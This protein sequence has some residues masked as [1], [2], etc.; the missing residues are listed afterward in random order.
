MEVLG[1]PSTSP[2]STILQYLRRNGQATIKD[3]ECVLG[4]STTAVRE[5]L[6]HLQ[7]QAFVST[8]TKRYGPGRPRLVYTLTDKAQRLFPKNYDLLI[9]LLLQEIATEEGMQKVEHL[10]HRV[11]MRLASDYA[12]RMSGEDIQDR[13]AEL[14]TKLEAQGIPSDI[15]PSGTGIRLF[16][17]PY[18]NVA[19]SHMEVCE[20][21]KQ[22]VEQV[23]GKKVVQ[24]HSIL[25]GDHHC[26]FHVG[27]LEE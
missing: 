10:L 25:E 3:L 9:H 5:H 20:M 7:S 14:R 6:A 12:D 21:E 17:C 24:E 18:H 22:M 13:L 26:C 19:Q 2:A 16:S 8:S 11:S 27:E 15:Q 4:V 1:F 23:L